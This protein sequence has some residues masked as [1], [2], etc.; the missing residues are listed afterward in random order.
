M[1]DQNVLFE[2]RMIPAI[3]YILLLYK[4]NYTQ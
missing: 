4:Y 2:V 3:S 1:D